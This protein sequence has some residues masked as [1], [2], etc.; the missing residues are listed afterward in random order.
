MYHRKLQ[1]VAGTT[2]T[3]SLPKE[4]IVKNHL[5]E[6]QELMI[7]EQEDGSLLVAKEQLSTL[8]STS[9]AL[10]VG[11]LTDT[12]ENILLELYYL[13]FETI[14]LYASA[15]LSTDAKSKIRRMRQCLSGAEITHADNHKMVLKILLDRTKIDMVQLLYRVSLIIDQS[16][17]NLQEN[18]DMEELDINEQEIDRLYHL[19]NKI[20]YLSLQ[21]SALLNSSKIKDIHWIPSYILIAKKLENM[22]DEIYQLGIHCKNTAKKSSLSPKIIEYFRK[23]LNR[24]IHHILSDYPSGFTSLEK[25]EREEINHQI[26]NLKDSL[27]REHLAYCLR[28]LIDI[29]DK[30]IHI[31]FHKRLL[32][33]KLC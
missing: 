19:I 5:R 9:I 23:N 25:S 3:L 16:L 24:S 22:G 8:P 15:K 30:I 18:Q 21:D 4:W 29:E 1:L 10:N 11:A 26:H 6:Q 7:S 27:I 12:L 28:F 32:T 31:S 33:Q 20:L 14:E 13:G 17:Q 2:Y